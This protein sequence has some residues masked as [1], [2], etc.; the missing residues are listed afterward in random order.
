MINNTTRTMVTYLRVSLRHLEVGD[1]LDHSTTNTQCYETIRRIEDVFLGTRSAVL[2]DQ[3]GALRAVTLKSVGWH[4][5]VSG[6]KIAAAR[7]DP[8]LVIISPAGHPTW[9]GG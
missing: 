2:E 8:T 4:M 3:H 1:V 7:R 5:V 6:E 9:K